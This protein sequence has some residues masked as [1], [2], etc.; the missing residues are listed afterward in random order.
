M[1]NEI[2]FESFMGAQQPHPRQDPLL[3]LITDMQGSRFSSPDQPMPAPQL[4]TDPGMENQ[5][6]RSFWTIEYYQK[7]FDVN[8][9]DVLQRILTSIVPNR[10]SPSYFDQNISVKP[11]LYGPFWVSTTLIFAIAISGNISNYLQHAN[12]GYHWKYDFHL[13]SYAATAIFCY[14]WIVP[15]G[16]WGALKWTTPESSIEMAEEGQSNSPSMMSLFCIYG[17]SL[18]I[19]I[20]VSI[21]WTIQVSW[22]QWLLVLTAAL[23]S[24]LVLVYL[25]LPAL[26]RSQRY[27]IL[28]ACILGFHFLLAAGFMLY[29]F[30]VPSSK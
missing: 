28:I 3:D 29:F 10:A 18:S 27:I 26:K 21:L 1:S 25:L 17:Y 9:D 2:G 30:H 16:L 4:E 11:D 13:V 8:T 20:P 7:Y 14:T 23:L 24:G 15:L 12:T 22:L 19:Y 5:K 6:N